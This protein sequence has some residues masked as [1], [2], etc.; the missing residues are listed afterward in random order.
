M[1]TWLLLLSKEYI[2]VW[3]LSLAALITVNDHGIYIG[4]VSVTGQ[5]NASQVTIQIKVFEDDLANALHAA[6]ESFSS[7]HMNL[8][9]EQSVALAIKYFS[10]HLI[11]TIAPNHN[12][13]NWVLSEVVQTNE[14]VLFTFQCE[15]PVDWTGLSVKADFF[16]EL[17]PTQSNVVQVKY[18][19][20][21]K[22]LRLT[23]KNPAKEI[24][25]P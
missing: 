4:T 16:T 21:H 8:D 20:F 9:D 23:K 12:L 10:Q 15:G 14:I 7:F 13:D 2:K 22:Y 17:F 6:Y 24:K 19:T 25:I 5:P 1:A 11:F 18:G 3:I